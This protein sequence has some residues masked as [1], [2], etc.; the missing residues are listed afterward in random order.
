MS[1]MRKFMVEH[2]N[3]DADCGAIQ[4]NW[5]KMQQLENST[6]VRTY[7]NYDEG[8][9]FCIWLAPDEEELKKIFR[10]MDVSWEKIIPVEETIPDMWGEKWGEHL[11]KEQY[12]DTLGF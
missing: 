8:W 6:W 5:R 7:I 1:K 12:S 11:R 4:D 9:R 3:P 10:E 2:Y